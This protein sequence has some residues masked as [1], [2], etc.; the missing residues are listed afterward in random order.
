[1]KKNN[2]YLLLIITIIIIVVIIVILSHQNEENKVTENK[3]PP[4][5]ENIPCDASLWQHVYHSYRLE[6]K[7]ECKVVTG[8]ID[9]LRKE[10]DGDYHIRLKL[11]SGQNNLLNEKN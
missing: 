7:E 6:V 8:T 4:L 2:K 5:S 11:D 9:F 3:S 10:A 1:M